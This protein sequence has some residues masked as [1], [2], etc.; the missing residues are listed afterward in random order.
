MRALA[1]FFLCGGLLSS[2]IAMASSN[3]DEFL[4]PD[5]ALAVDIDR[6][7]F[8]DVADE[9]LLDSYEKIGHLDFVHIDQ[10]GV[11]YE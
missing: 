5:D 10:R 3:C 7:C 9:G 8:V 4:L 11:L 1:M 2:N 6:F